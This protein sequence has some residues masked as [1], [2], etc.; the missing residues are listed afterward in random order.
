MLRSRRWY[1]NYLACPTSTSTKCKGLAYGDSKCPDDGE[2]DSEAVHL[3][4]T[5]PSNAAAE[6]SFSD[7]MSFITGFSKAE[8]PDLEPTHLYRS[9]NENTALRKSSSEVGKTEPDE[10]N[11][12]EI[13]DLQS[14]GYSCHQAETEREKGIEKWLLH[15]FAANVPTSLR[16]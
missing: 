15:T 5:A 3:L 1:D 14:L 12:D 8:C 13:M 16:S 10:L 2:K 11:G 6:K 7:L 4:I 9:V